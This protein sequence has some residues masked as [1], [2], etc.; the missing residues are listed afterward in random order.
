MASK[1]PAMHDVVIIGGGPAG[2]HVGARLAARGFDT[3][4]LEEH[5]TIG[6]PVHCTGVLAA[7]A[8]DEFG[9]SRRSVLNELTTARFWSP[10]GHDI[11]YSGAKVEAVVVDRRAFDEELH[12]IAQT[13][14]VAVERGA[15]ATGIQID[16][17]G[18][19]VKTPSGEWRA[20]VCVLACGANYSL[21]RQVGLEMPGLF[22]HT[23]QVEL[24]A[25]HSGDVELHFGSIVAPK[26]FG[27]VVPVARGDHGCAR[28]GVMCE[29][30]APHHFDRLAD[31]VAGRWRINREQIGRP[32]QKIL[33][34]APIS[35]TYGDRLVAIGD[36]AGLVKPTTGGGIYY[37][38]LSASLAADVL[39]DALADDDLGAARLAPYEQQWR[40]RL[41]DEF[42][43][44][45]SLRSVAHRMTDDDIEQLFELARTDGVMPIVR[46][47]ASFNRH[48]NLILALL[49]HPPVRQILRRRFAF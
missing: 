3:A 2:L 45:L 14:G 46:R 41:D 47:T 23:A 32:R 21:H 20:R 19:S 33:P 34:L 18:V 39:A 11:T 48:R 43:A 8:F 28:V 17:S 49:R 9:L 36:A 26:G 12:D 38:L 30:D 35:R 42:H 16:A 31:R 29:H 6:E 7:E 44:Q 27:W 25:Q 1:M 22:L 5:P 40:D 4:L 10:A 37:S 13:A 15:R 24:P